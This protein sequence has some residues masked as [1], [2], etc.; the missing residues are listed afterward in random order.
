VNFQLL[1][2]VSVHWNQLQPARNCHRPI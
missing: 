1:I 2:R